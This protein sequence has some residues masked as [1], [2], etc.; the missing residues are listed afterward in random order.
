MST[1]NHF[2]NA[3]MHSLSPYQIDSVPT[4][5]L[6]FHEAV[7][8]T[9][10]IPHAAV[11]FFIADRYFLPLFRCPD[12][13]VESLRRYSYVI[14]P[15]VSQY[16][17]YSEEVRFNNHCRNLAMGAYLQSVGIIVIA[18]ANV[19]WSL[20]DSYDYAFE[21]LPCHTTIAINSNGANADGYTR[22]LWLQGYHKAIEQLS[23]THILRYGSPVPGE[24]TDISTYYPNPYIARLRE[25][26]RKHKMPTQTNDIW[27]TTIDFD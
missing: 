4:V 8:A 15:D 10:S 27:Q 7:R 21:G 25:L 13:Y 19:T 1:Y 2:I 5:L 11:H 20:P 14:M 26:P 6:P 12:C 3:P 17:D 24:R 18:I 23:P 9:A 16:R 22:F